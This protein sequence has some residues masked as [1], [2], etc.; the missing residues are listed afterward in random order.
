MNK[1]L[2]SLHVGEVIAIT[3][4]TNLSE[5]ISASN[6]SNG[7]V[8]L[9]FVVWV[10]FENIVKKPISLFSLYALIQYGRFLSYK[11]HCSQINNNKK[12]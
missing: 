4:R 7:K 12:W 10:P 9:K 1:H 3:E 11:S 2:E 6:K 5:T 8:K